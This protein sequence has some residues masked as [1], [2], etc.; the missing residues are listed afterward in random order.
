VNQ[1]PGD[2]METLQRSV[3]RLKSLISDLHRQTLGGRSVASVE[4]TQQ[5]AVEQVT[6]VCDAASR[7]LNALERA[8][9]GDTSTNS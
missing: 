7:T 2:E 8:T 3:D 6:G 9:A 4:G 5:T 1:S